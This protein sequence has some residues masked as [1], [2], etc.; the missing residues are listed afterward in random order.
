VS[1]GRHRDAD[2]AGPID[3]AIL[4]VSDTRTTATDESGALLRSLLE[5][6][7]HRVCLQRVV[8]DEPREIRAAVEEIEAN[9]TIRVV[10]INGGTGITRR[11]HTFETITELIERPLAGFGELFRSLSFAE[12]GPAAMLSRATA[13]TRGRLAIFSVPGSPAAVR[14]AA[15][16]LIVP[17][18]S[19]L[20]GQMDRD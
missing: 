15:E 12:V 6:A 17:Q 20:V 3:C 19:H 8:R 18:L 4:S 16:R 5:A 1:G 11:D 14:L 10:V 7:G 13:G 2:P 9:P